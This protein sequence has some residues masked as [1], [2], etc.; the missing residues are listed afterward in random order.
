MKRKSKHKQN[1][2]KSREA[3]GASFGM[4]RAVTHKSKKDY[5]RKDEH[6]KLRKEYGF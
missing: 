3:Q 4:I 2:E 5:N 6:L 1:Y